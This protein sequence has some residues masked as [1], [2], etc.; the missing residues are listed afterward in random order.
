VIAIGLVVADFDILEA[1]QR[2]RKINCH[3]EDMPVIDSLGICLGKS[4]DV[5]IMLTIKT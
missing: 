1:I 3:V 2:T 5:T 4:I